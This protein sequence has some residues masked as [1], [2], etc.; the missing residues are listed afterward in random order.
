MLTRPGPCVAA[1]EEE[2]VSAAAPIS[3]VYSD[4]E[5]SAL[6]SLS[7]ARAYRQNGLVDFSRVE[8]VPGIFLANQISVS[9]L[10]NYD[11]DYEKYISTKVL[12]HP[13][14]ALAN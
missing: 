2:F 13:S 6:F 8:G 9:A 12:L 1:D 3:N 4:G 10:E 11:Y 5:G 7:L 14:T